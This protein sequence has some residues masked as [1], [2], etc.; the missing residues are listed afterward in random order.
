MQR[1]RHCEAVIALDTLSALSFAAA[2]CTCLVHETHNNTWCLPLIPKY[3]TQNRHSH[4]SPYYFKMKRIVVQ[5]PED[6]NRQIQSSTSAPSPLPAAETK[7]I[8]QTR[9]RQSQS[10]PPD[11]MEILVPSLKVGAAAGTVPQISAAHLLSV[12]SDN[13]RCMRCIYWS[14]GRHHSVCAHTILLSHRRRT[15]VYLGH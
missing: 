10:L 1:P 8:E 7:P 12:F 4:T 11:L 6:E 2:P 3:P 9:P 13:P 14:R 5:N 15:V